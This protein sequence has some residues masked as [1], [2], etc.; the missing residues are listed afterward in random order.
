MKIAYDPKV[1]ALYIRFIEEPMECEVIRLNRQS[2][3]CNY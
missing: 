3:V 2:I 1:D